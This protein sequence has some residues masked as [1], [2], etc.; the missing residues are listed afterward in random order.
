M[1]ENYKR[2]REREKK[3]INEKINQPCKFHHLFFAVLSNIRLLG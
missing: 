3:K 2:D 1:L